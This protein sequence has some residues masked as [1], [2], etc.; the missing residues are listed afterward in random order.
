M[1]G[2]SSEDR[3]VVTGIG[4]VTPLGNDVPTF[5]DNLLAGACGIDAITAFDVSAY[6]CRIAAQV[7]E[8]DPKPAFP[9]PKDV[10][11]A[12]RWKVDGAYGP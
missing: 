2:Q 1:S 7:N 8:F 5:W 3:V 4:L 9:S 10:R 6:A 12:D 11:R